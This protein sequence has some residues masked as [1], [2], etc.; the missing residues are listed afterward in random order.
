[1]FGGT[2]PGSVKEI[3]AGSSWLMYAFYALTW[4]ATAIVAAIVLHHI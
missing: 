2:L 1:M 4:I 3:D